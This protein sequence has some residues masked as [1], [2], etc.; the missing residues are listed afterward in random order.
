[1]TRQETEQKY[2]K[3]FDEAESQ[4]VSLF[5]YCRMNGLKY[6]AYANYRRRHRSDGETDHFE[7]R[8][9]TPDSESDPPI[10]TVIATI[11]GTEV[12]IGYLSS[13][14]LTE[15]LEAIKNV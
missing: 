1:M 14:E 12:T 10:H 9:L 5:E 4:H 13:S 15:I 6:S 3:A 11:G 7:I 8:K 2:V